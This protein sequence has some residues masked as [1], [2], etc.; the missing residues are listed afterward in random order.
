MYNLPK[1][2]IKVVS[3]V[4]RESEALLDTCCMY[5]LS[6]CV[7]A[8]VGSKLEYNKRGKIEER[9]K[10]IGEQTMNGAEGEL[11]SFAEAGDT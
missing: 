7:K 8:L 1:T 5:S 9:M 11:K 4:E 2:T 3:E 6:S 10:K